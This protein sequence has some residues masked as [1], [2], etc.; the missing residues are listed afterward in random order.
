[1]LAGLVVLGGVLLILSWV[2][3]TFPP[4]MLMPCSGYAS[5]VGSEPDV[6][7][8]LWVDDSLTDGPTMTR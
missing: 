2:T 5:C 3:V 4:R 6:N 1:V 8:V 7:Q